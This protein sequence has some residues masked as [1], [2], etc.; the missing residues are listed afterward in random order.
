MANT[1]AP[2]GLINPRLVTGGSPNQHHFEISSTYAKTFFPG[3]IVMKN[4][5]GWAEVLDN[6]TQLTGKTALGVCMGHIPPP[7][8]YSDPVLKVPVVTDLHNTLWEIQT[9]LTVAQVDGGRNGSELLGKNLVFLDMGTTNRDTTSIKR[10]VSNMRATKA[11]TNGVAAG[12]LKVWGFPEDETALGKH[13]QEELANPRCLVKFNE[14][15][16]LVF[17]AQTAAGV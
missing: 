11:G 7:S 15:S 4:N 2:R 16:G 9:S 5:L 12:P 6:V 13:N 14:R 10:K 17:Y 8:G 1:S 3:D